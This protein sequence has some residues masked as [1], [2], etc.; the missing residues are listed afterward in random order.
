MSMWYSKALALF[1]LLR[2]LLV[3]V[4]LLSLLALP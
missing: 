4:V 2:V 3:C 1:L